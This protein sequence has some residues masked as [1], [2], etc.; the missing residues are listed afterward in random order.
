MRADAD[1]LCALDLL[2]QAQ[3]HLEQATL[4]AFLE[5]ESRHAT[6]AQALIDWSRDRHKAARWMMIQRCAFQGKSGYE[7]VIEGDTDTL[8]EYISALS[9][10]RHDAYRAY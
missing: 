5:F 8:W 2:S 7:L 10:P 1:L 3:H 6:F 4:S 9:C